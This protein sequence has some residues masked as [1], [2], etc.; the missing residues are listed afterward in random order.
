MEV[1]EMGWEGKVD[2]K[3]AN[4]VCRGDFRTWV[5]HR[6]HQEAN[7]SHGGSVCSVHSCVP[8]TCNSNSPPPPP[9][10]SAF[11]G[12]HNTHNTPNV[13]RV[14]DTRLQSTGVMRGK[15]L[16]TPGE[17]GCEAVTCANSRMAAAKQERAPSCEKGNRK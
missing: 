7:C 16:R 6:M 15:S 14:L 4:R 8:G 5:Q 12:W 10:P 1:L 13:H 2:R 17:M 3:L 11:T 9:L